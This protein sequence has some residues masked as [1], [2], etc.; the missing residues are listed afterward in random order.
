VNA[1]GQTFRD[2]VRSQI[3]DDII[4]MMF[5]IGPMPMDDSEFLRVLEMVGKRIE[6]K[7]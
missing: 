1:S 5:I 4:D 7:K 3:P 2:Q 6:E